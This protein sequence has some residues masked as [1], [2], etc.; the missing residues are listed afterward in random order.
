M[1]RATGIVRR[2][3]DLGRIVIPKEIR[4]KL[5]FRENDP[6]EFFF[7][8]NQAGLVIRK[9]HPIS[10]Y[11]FKRYASI[12]R[13]AAKKSDVAIKFYFADRDGINILPNEKL[14]E[15]MK[16]FAM[17]AAESRA[18]VF[19][20]VGPETRATAFRLEIDD[21]LVAAMLIIESANDEK[22]VAA[23]DVM[24]AMVVSMF[25]NENAI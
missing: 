10:S 12:L 15:D 19:R 7:T 5:K 16:S 6:L 20:S 3:D 4:R 13:A 22:S 14:S 1:E 24:G 17:E 18:R 23:V 9:Y 11:D 21:E 8:E 25:E 2:L